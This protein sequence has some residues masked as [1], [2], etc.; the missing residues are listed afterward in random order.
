M[1]KW[2]KTHIAEDGGFSLTEIVMVTMLMSVILAAA[3]LA[4]QTV[5]RTSDGMMARSQAQDSGQVAIERMT[6]EIRQAQTITDAST[7]KVWRMASAS[8]TSISFWADINHDGFLDR[9]TYTLSGG[10]VT[11]KVAVATKPYPGPNDFGADSAPSVITAVDP[12]L[13]SMFT[14][15]NKDGNTT[16]D[17]SDAPLTAVTAVKVSMRTLGTSGNQ[18]ISVDFPPA[19]AQVRSF[20]PGIVP[21]N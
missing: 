12:S 20:G 8:A 19:Y 9:V 14:L 10:Q 16:T 6:R 21:W 5:N 3:Y 7:G 15:L 18:S 2:L 13:T 11:R 4:L 17:I 1:T